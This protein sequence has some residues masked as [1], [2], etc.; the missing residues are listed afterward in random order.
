M[1]WHDG[2]R[3]TGSIIEQVHRQCFDAKH[4]TELHHV[5]DKSDS[6][7]NVRHLDTLI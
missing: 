4:Y 3:H 7:Y 1:R 6:L 2:N 5:H